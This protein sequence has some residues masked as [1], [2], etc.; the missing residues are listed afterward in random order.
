MLI[1]GYSD[2]ARRERRVPTDS[3]ADVYQPGDPFWRAEARVAN[4]SANGLLL[5]MTA[6]ENLAVGARLNVRF[7]TAAV[8]GVVKHVSPGA[9]HILVGIAIDN[10]QYLSEQ[11]FGL[12]GRP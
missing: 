3:A 6:A 4:V 11:D 8:A 9:A 1:N 7:G 10:V 5:K 12:C 2:G